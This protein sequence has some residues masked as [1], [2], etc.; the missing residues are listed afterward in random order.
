[1]GVGGHLCR[2]KAFRFVHKSRWGEAWNRSPAELRQPAE[3]ASRRTL[4]FESR[5]YGRRFAHSVFA[6]AFMG[7]K[8][9]HWHCYPPIWESLLPSK[10]ARPS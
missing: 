4:L 9:S 8:R 5:P 1:M 2:R 10:F 3:R 6:S 7:T